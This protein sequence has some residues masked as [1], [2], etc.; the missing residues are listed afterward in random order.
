MFN[1]SWIAES[2]P[3]L[4]PPALMSDANRYLG[5]FLE[6]LLSASNLPGCV[7]ITTINRWAFLYWP[8]IFILQ[9]VESFWC[10]LVL[11]QFEWD[12]NLKFK[13]IGNFSCNYVWAPKKD[14]QTLKQSK[15]LD[16]ALAL[17]QR[18]RRLRQAGE[19]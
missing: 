7:T 15:F 17:P 6:I 16:L 1:I 12:F 11:L 2:H 13:M 4:N 19:A 10:L 5:I 3:I 14:L 8:S 9:Y 18:L